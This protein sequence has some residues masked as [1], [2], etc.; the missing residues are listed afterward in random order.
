MLCVW[1]DLVGYLNLLSSCWDLSY[2]K[3]CSCLNVSGQVYVIGS[4]SICSAVCF[5]QLKFC[6]DAV[7]YCANQYMI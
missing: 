7:G 4:L 2:Y 6:T 1:R 3:L 5:F